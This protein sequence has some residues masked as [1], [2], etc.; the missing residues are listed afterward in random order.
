LQVPL[1]IAC[2]S[3]LLAMI[4]IS[5]YKVAVDGYHIPTGSIY[6]MDLSYFAVAFSTTL[7]SQLF[8]MSVPGL[9][10]PLSEKDRPHALGYFGAALC[11]TAGLYMVFSIS[12]S[13]AFAEPKD[14]ANLMFH[15][16]SLGLATPA[17]LGTTVSYYP[18]AAITAVYPLLS[19]T[20]GDGL[21]SSCAQS[22]SIWVKNLFRLLASVPPLVC[23][24]YDPP[25]AEVFQLAGLGG[26]GVAFVAPVALEVSSRRAIR[27]FLGAPPSISRATMEDRSLTPVPLAPFY[28][29]LSGNRPVQ[30]VFVCDFFCFGM[31]FYQFLESLL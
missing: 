20:L 24:F 16:L 8:Q 9:L 12:C 22:Q 28:R 19:I 13:L 31:T 29:T 27:A 6:G 14:S 11:T 30:V 5:C 3:A 21:R 23:A 1:F 10:R 7:F 18:L 15:G 26:I 17:W 25:L 4:Y 2:M